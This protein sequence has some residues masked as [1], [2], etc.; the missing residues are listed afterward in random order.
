MTI[1]YG[2]A[3]YLLFGWVILVMLHD[4]MFADMSKKDLSD[5]Q[6]DAARGILVLIWPLIMLL[7]AVMWTVKLAI[8]AL[9]LMGMT[10]YKVNEWIRRRCT[11]KP[12]QL[13]RCYFCK[14]ERLYDSASFVFDRRCSCR[15][16][17]STSPSFYKV[18]E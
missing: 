12:K 8:D 6:L 13:W 3:L 14:V 9:V 17:S 7:V 4:K 16:P 2:I 18:R 10:A 1:L 5:H 15:G 11:K